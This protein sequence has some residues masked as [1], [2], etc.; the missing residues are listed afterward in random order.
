MKT[1]AKSRAEQASII[2]TEMG[3]MKEQKEECSVCFCEEVTMRMV[4][5]S[6]EIGGNSLLAHDI[7]RDS[8]TCRCLLLI[9]PLFV[10]ISSNWLIA[11][12]ASVLNV[13]EDGSC[14]K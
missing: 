9:H 6:R 4:M 14:N 3:K 13:W 10:R 11:S 12:I 8:S 2:H 5:S 1:N 7:N